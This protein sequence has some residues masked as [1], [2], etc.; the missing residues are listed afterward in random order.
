MAGSTLITSPSPHLP[1]RGE[2]GCRSHSP[3]SDGAGAATAPPLPPLLASLR[4]L[5]SPA[6]KDSLSDA[7]FSPGPH[8]GPWVHVRLWLRARGGRPRRC[9]RG[10]RRA[11]RRC[12][13]AAPRAHRQQWCTTDRDCAFIYLTG[14]GTGFAQHEVWWTVCHEVIAVCDCRGP[15]RWLISCIKTKSLEQRPSDRLNIETRGPQ[16]NIY[17]GKLELVRTGNG[18]FRKVKDG[19]HHKMCNSVDLKCVTTQSSP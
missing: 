5:R 3:A 1:R 13:R 12:P 8:V 4:Q 7:R 10:V 19:H 2:A 6:T 16:T 14:S 15:V 18:M 9:A 11:L 17:V